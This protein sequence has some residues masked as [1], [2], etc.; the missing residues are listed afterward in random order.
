MGWIPYQ[1]TMCVY[2]CIYKRVTINCPFERQVFRIKFKFNGL[3][4]IFSTGI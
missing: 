3:A 4:L 1:L 2:T